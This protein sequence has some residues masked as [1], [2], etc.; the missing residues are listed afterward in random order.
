MEVEM[1]MEGEVLAGVGEHK[2]RQGGYEESE[3]RK[4]D[5]EETEDSRPG[6]WNSLLGPG[7]ECK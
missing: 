3:G 5:R 2:H 1:G 4:E 6:L 7:H